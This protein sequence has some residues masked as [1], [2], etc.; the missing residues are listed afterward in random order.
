MIDTI[1]NFLGTGGIAQLSTGVLILTG[2]VLTQV[3]I[4]GV[5]VYLHRHQA[6]RALE[7]HPAIAHFFRFWLWM[8]TGMVTREF[9]SRDR[10]HD[11]KCDTAE[12]PHSPRVLGI[13][14]VLWQGSELLR[15][16]AG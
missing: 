14:T 15:E 1:L 10:K 11:A 4:E 13:N 8:T 2:L 6:H 12:D 3:T 7:L 16:E 5:T 9:V